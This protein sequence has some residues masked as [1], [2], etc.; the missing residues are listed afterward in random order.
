MNRLVICN[1][2]EME[3]CASVKVHEWERKSLNG[4]FFCELIGVFIYIHLESLK[5]EINF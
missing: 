5:E 4:I 1:L 3:L 2:K